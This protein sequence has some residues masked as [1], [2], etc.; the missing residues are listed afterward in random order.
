MNKA[1]T[2]LT[3]TMLIGFL[4]RWKLAYSR[5]VREK[6]K[7]LYLRYKRKKTIENYFI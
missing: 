4:E 7:A 1:T 5:K 3:F 2:S 6:M